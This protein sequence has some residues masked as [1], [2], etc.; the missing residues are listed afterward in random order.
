MKITPLHVTI[1]QFQ[2]NLSKVLEYLILTVLK[3]FTYT[4]YRLKDA[5]VKE[6]W[7]SKSVT[8]W[9]SWGKQA[10]ARIYVQAFHGKTRA[11]NKTKTTG[12]QTNITF[13]KSQRTKATLSL[14]ML[15][16]QEANKLNKIRYKLTTNTT[17]DRKWHKS[18]GQGTENTTK[19]RKRWFVQSHLF[20]KTKI[21]R[22]TLKLQK[23]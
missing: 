2:N 22:N 7:Q 4:K 5:L 14:Y 15:C 6:T 8:L 23:L 16:V 13:N 1:H 11:N 10:E 9:R 21:K 3:Y 12:K 20:S 19:T 18:P 17:G